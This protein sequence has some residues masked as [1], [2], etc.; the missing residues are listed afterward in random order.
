[1]KKAKFLRFLALALLLLCLAPGAL[2]AAPEAI[3]MDREMTYA[4]NLF[5]SNFTEVGLE[6]AD[7]YAGDAILVDFAH[8]HLWF[9]SYDSFEY[10]DYFNGNNCRVAD[11][12]IQ[13]I[14]DQYF[15]HAPTV[16]LR[17]TRFD[18]DG[19]YYYHCETGGWNNSGF[20][21][22][23]DVRSAG[24]DEYFVSFMVFDNGEF[25]DV[26]VMDDPLTGLLD[27]YG[28]PRSYG[29]ALVHASDLADRSTYSMISYSAL[30]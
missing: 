17:Q 23:L 22:A 11:N 25:W 26:E 15:Y 2:A 18:Y 21:H 8:D 14:I 10:G 4:M 13:E 1:M 19:E 28:A 9:N 24:Q 6:Q 12:R 7:A 30:L 3:E 29:C 5:L 27:R 16:D 20:A